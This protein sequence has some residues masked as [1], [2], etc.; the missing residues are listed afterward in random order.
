M[1]EIIAAIGIVVSMA[2]LPWWAVYGVLVLTLIFSRGYAAIIGAI[3]LDV[4]AL[5]QMLPYASI[6]FLVLAL[7]AYWVK[8]NMVGRDSM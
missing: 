5:P 6:S 4:Y 8:T 7:I 3:F 1:R 2:F